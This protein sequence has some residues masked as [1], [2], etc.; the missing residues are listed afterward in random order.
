M[1]VASGS[2]IRSWMPV[3]DLPPGWEVHHHNERRWLTDRDGNEQ[4]WLDP[5]VQAELAK[6]DE[7]GEDCEWF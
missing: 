2:V 1:H 5:E 4:F 7:K 3:T 6:D